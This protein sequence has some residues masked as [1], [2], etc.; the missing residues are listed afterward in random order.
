MDNQRSFIIFVTIVLLVYAALNFYVYRRTM[1]AASPVGGWL[2][3]LR[4]VLWIGILSYP[5][6]RIIGLT[7]GMGA[8][9]FRVGSFWLAVMTYGVLLAALVD[10]IRLIGLLTG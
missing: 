2:W 8:F 3:V 4:V 6:G 7:N 5:L 1:Q 9:L 10:V